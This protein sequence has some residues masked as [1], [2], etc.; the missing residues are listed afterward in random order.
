MPRIVSILLLLAAVSLPVAAEEIS[1]KD[2]TKIVGHM[3]AVTA[4]KV[5]VE[6]SYGKMQ[7]KRS[8]I[9]TISFPE[10]APSNTGESTAT[11]AKT[12][13]PKVDESL[14]GVR[15]VNR[16]GKFSL[17]LPP[18]WVINSDLKRN[19][20]TLTLLNSAD[21]M[22]LMMVMEEEYPGSL[23]SY[24]EL[25]MLNARKILTN[26]EE[27]AQSNVTIDGKA[28]LLV[29]YRGVPQKAAFP[30]AFVSAIIPSGN[31]YTK[32]T[33]WCVE[34]LFHDMQPTFEKMLMSYHTT[35]QTTT[36]AASSKP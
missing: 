8:D 16:T 26:F 32:M 20:G 10:N 7:L 11:A 34:P 24:K 6:T 2:G 22:R 19:P 36:A 29:F 21:K 31:S 4:D 12:D 18:Q 17:T 23:D 3:T 1:L 27:S 15:Y 13:A 35:G 5:E 25:T 9:V 14:Q 28:A 30:L 33:I